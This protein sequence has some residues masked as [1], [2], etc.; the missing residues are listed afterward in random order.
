MAELKIPRLEVQK[1]VGRSY[2][3]ENLILD[4]ASLFKSLATEMVAKK[5]NCCQWVKSIKREQHYSH[6]EIVVTYNNSYRSVYYLSA[7]SF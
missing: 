7:T 1:K 4:E 5:I 6:V 3:I 2:Q